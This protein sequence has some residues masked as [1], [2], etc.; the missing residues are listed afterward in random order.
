ITPS[1]QITEFSI[2]GGGDRQTRGIVAG[3]DG[4]LWFREVYPDAIGKITTGGQIT[5][6]PLPQGSGHPI[7]L[8]AGPDGNV[9]FTVFEPDA[10]DRIT[11]GGQIT[12]FPLASS[13][14]TPYGITAGPDE[15]LWFT[16]RE[17]NKIG[18][19]TT[20]GELTE[21]PLP[22]TERGAEEITTGPDGNLWFTEAGAGRL[23]R[24]TPIG[25]VTEYL[26]PTENS[27]PAG[28]AV[29]PDGNLWFAEWLADKIGRVTFNPVVAAPEDITPPS[30]SGNPIQGRILSASS[31]SWSNEPTSYTYQWEDCDS[32]GNACVPIA[33]AQASTYM[34][35]E[36]DLGHTIRVQVSATNDAGTGGPASSAATAVVTAEST[37]PPSIDREWVTGVTSSNATLNAEINPHGLL[38]KYKLQIDTTGHFKFDQNDSCALHP[39]GIVCAQIVISGEPL[40]PGLVEP[41]ESTLAAGFEDQHVSVNLASIGATLQPIT[42]YHYRAIA[43]NSK[44]FVAGPDQTFTT[45]PLSRP[46]QP[47]P[48]IDDE[49]VSNI[50]QTDATL[51]AQINPNSVDHGAYYQFQVVTNTSEYLPE[52]ACPTEGF[53]AGTSLCLTV[54]SQAGALPIS[55]AAAAT[56]DQSV[57]LDLADAGMTLHPGTTYHYRVIT[58]RAIQTVD[59]INWED[60]IVYGSDRTFTTHHSTVIVDPLLP[61]APPETEG[62]PATTSTTP[63]VP[64]QVGGV[65]LTTHPTGCW[66]TLRNRRARSRVAGPQGENSRAKHLKLVR[67]RKACR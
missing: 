33:G 48:S 19:I 43:A 23:G 31:G 53:P 56:T 44:G 22:H 38:T 11:P 39:P 24:I 18:R 55:F 10:I 52:F 50:T 26:T 2:P 15:N 51:E 41:P 49:S 59:T 7:Q 14:N 12:E 54:G 3:S 6:Y 61:V 57:I 60:P 9:W 67:K 8:A 65:T 29:G 42:T 21:F 64:N 35:T 28:I 17:S 16:E 47:P 46:P 36:N 66:H 62:A 5:E 1:G 63:L 30:I 37:G 34:L 58:A 13:G 27:V 20:G 4:N 40:P 25:Q 32:A 45:Q